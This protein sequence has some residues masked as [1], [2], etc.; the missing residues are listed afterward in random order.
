MKLDLDGSS[1]REF[2][3]YADGR[4]KRARCYFR[5]DRVLPITGEIE[6]LLKILK[7]EST[8]SGV[9]G[10]LSSIAESN[11]EAIRPWRKLLGT[12]LQRWK[13]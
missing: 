6:L 12:L 4:V 5:K 8:L 9:M 10:A 7:Q 2:G 1:V 3:V 13:R 11:A